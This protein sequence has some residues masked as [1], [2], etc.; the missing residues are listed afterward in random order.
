M[1]VETTD[2][3][4]AVCRAVMREMDG[5]PVALELRRPGYAPRYEATTAGGQTIA[6]QWC[7]ILMPTLDFVSVRAQLHCTGG[8]LY[9]D[10]VLD[11][12]DDTPFCQFLFVRYP[13]DPAAITGPGYEAEL[14]AAVEKAVAAVEADWARVRAEHAAKTAGGSGE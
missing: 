1:P 14:R 6:W 8:V 11:P 10:A 9:R 7:V 2:L 13:A 12:G 4:A 3:G 5:K